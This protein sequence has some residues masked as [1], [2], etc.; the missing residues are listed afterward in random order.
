MG[1]GR[2][3]T[4]EEHSKR[5]D[6]VVG[7]IITSDLLGNLLSDFGDDQGKSSP[8][9]AGPVREVGTPLSL[10]Q[11]ISKTNHLYQ[12]KGMAAG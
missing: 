9:Q 8:A 10:N 6:G 5:I 7:S 1:A 2:D 3:S 12:Q 4:L 11:T